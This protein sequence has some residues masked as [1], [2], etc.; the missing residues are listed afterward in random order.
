M[1][2]GQRLRTNVAL[3][4]CEPCHS[5]C[6]PSVLNMEVKPR[7]QNTPIQVQRLVRLRQGASSKG[8]LRATAAPRMPEEGV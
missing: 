1:E 8:K 7:H 4:I 6:M 5:L 3:F 2:A